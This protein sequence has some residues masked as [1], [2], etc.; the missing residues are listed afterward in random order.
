[1]LSNGC[2]LFSSSQ[3]STS[4]LIRDEAVRAEAVTRAARAADVPAAGCRRS[5]GTGNPQGT[6]LRASSYGRGTRRIFPVAARRDGPGAGTARR[7]MRARGAGWHIRIRR[8]RRPPP[9]VP[10]VRVR[11]GFPVRTTAKE[12]GWTA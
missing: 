1:M 11:P 9:A 6:W 7:E 4:G 12:S 3:A 2:R 8:P 5:A 10:A